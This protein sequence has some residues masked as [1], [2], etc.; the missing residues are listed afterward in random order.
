MA[1]FTATSQR[2]KNPLTRRLVN[3]KLCAS[4]KNLR[5]EEAYSEKGKNI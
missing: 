1:E 3:D 4:T 5:N 2:A